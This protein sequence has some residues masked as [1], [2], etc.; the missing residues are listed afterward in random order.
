MEKDL[1]EITAAEEEAKA[2]FEDMVAAKTK[3]INALTKEVED[4][5]TRLGEVGV[6]LVNMRE[7]L[8]DT[9]KSLAEDK[10]FLADMDKLC[11]EKKQEWAERSKT[12]ADELLALADTIKLLND[13][14]ALDLFK[15]TLP[16][17]ALVQV[18]V[19]A[20]EVRS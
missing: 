17:P 1:A 4:K 12:R 9:Q 7:D 15:K 18:K 16:T 3:Q 20:K 6:A 11:E 10:K 8:D 14:D 2:T 19:G 5:L 13:D